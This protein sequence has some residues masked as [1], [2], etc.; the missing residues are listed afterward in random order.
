MHK[1][2]DNITGTH[3]QKIKRTKDHRANDHIQI[4]GGQHVRPLSHSSSFNAD[5]PCLTLEFCASPPEKKGHARKLLRWRSHQLRQRSLAWRRLPQTA[6]LNR[7]PFQIP[8]W[9]L[10]AFLSICFINPL[11]STRCQRHFCIA[12]IFFSICIHIPATN[13]A[14]R[15]LGVL[16]DDQVP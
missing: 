9:G 13:V 11:T 12:Y 2:C 7:S 1:R 10:E 5:R 14:L 8:R 3:N 16:I 6:Y 4:T 15:V